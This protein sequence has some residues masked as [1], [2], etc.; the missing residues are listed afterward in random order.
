M[1]NHTQD[2][3]R[4]RTNERTQ[5]TIQPFEQIA[6][7]VGSRLP[8]TNHLPHLSLI[9]TMTFKH[10]FEQLFKQLSLKQ[11]T[12]KVGNHQ[13]SRM[14]DTSPHKFVNHF[15]LLSYFNTQPLFYLEFKKYSPCQLY[16]YI[17]T[18]N[19]EIDRPPQVL[20]DS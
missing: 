13:I 10:L 3:Q 15:L 17:T 19:R 16:F 14:G 20:Y 12:F 11:T 2:K 8:G 4:T 1:G 18:I 5:A 9:L 6:K 7:W